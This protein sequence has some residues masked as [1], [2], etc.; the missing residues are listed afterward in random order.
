MRTFRRRG[1]DRARQAP[2][3][4][5]TASQLAIAAA[6][7]WEMVADQK[8]KRARNLAQIFGVNNAYVS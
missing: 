3:R 4:N 1:Y 2:C 6:E 5:L 8:G 7:A